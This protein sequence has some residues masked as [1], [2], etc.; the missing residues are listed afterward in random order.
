[1][2]VRL[3]LARLLSS[4]LSTATLSSF[5]RA[6][7]SLTLQ[8]QQTNNTRILTSIEFAGKN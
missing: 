7:Q 3:S 5:V 2:S 4:L 6:N 8:P 1:M